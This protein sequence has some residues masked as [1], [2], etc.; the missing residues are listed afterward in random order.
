VNSV[1]RTTGTDSNFTYNFQ[2]P[3]NENYD[4]VVVLD[5][6][7]PKTYY[8]VQSGY[9]TFTLTEGSSSATVTMTSKNYTATTFKSELTTAL[10]TASPNHWTYSITFDSSLGKY[11]YSLTGNDSQPSFTFTTNLNEQLGFEPN[12][13]N[14]FANNQLISTNV[15]DMQL[16][17]TLNI[18]SDMIGQG[19]TDNILQNV[20]AS[21]TTDFSNITW[22]CPDIDAY[23]KKLVT[24]TT[25]TYRFILTD[26][27]GTHEMNLNGKNIVMTIML[28]KKDSINTVIKEFLKQAY[29]KM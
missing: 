8:L 17:T 1:K 5:A 16:E 10:N 13:T 20:F 11:T 29:N 19:N 15:I 3:Q 25:N 7:I 23:S 12:T 21:G 22:I 26:E 27:D 18:R 2:I 14:I 9:N 28:Y 6:Y 24:N 4:N